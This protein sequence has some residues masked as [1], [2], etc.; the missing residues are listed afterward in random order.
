[1]HQYNMVVMACQT[2]LLDGAQGTRLQ[3]FGL[4]YTTS[5][6][7]WNIENPE[8]VSEIHRLYAE[9]G[10]QILLTNTFGALEPSEF[11]GALRCIEP[12]SKQCRIAGSIGPHTDI[13]HANIL[14][15]FIEFYVLETYSDLESARES[16]KF[17]RKL[18]SQW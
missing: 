13:R 16:L 1:M 9:A 10:S 15:S 3:K 8:K 18:G 6:P 14:T 12:F 4:P 11:E 5:S 7:R 17:L 2:I